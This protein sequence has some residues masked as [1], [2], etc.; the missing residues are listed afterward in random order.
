MFGCHCVQ[1]T[2]ITHS[3]ACAL[4][5][6]LYVTSGLD[7]RSIDPMYVRGYLDLPLS[8]TVIDRNSLSGPAQSFPVDTNRPTQIRSFLLIKT[9]SMS[10]KLIPIFLKRF[11]ICHKVISDHRV[12]QQHSDKW[13]LK[14]AL[15]GSALKGSSTLH[16]SV[17]HETGPG[18]DRDYFLE[19]L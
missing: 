5:P 18:P 3:T 4:A 7:P 6:C 2:R 13:I 14:I 11:W 16:L 19:R 12:N 10:L 9:Y 1:F 8:Q 17:C 15:K